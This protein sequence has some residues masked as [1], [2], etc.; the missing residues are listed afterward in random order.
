MSD[1][2]RFE[3]ETVINYNAEEKTATVYTRDK[4]V[5][6]KLDTLCARLPEHYK[7]ICEDSISR[8]YL[9]PKKLVRF[10]TISKQTEAQKVAFQEM[11]ER[12]RRERDGE[13]GTNT[14]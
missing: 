8:T 9:M 2:S 7:L 4:T 12:Q 5:M 13:G 3:M 10:G 6:R 14:G 11:L 1:L